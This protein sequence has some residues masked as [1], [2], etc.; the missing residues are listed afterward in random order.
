MFL[1][2]VVLYEIYSKKLVTKYFLHVSVATDMIFIKSHL[3]IFSPLIICSF[4]YIFHI[5]PHYLKTLFQSRL[6]F[7][8]DDLFTNK[9]RIKCSFTLNSCSILRIHLPTEARM[10]V[11]FCD[12]F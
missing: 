11:V 9:G 8:F 5:K 10:N 1:N 12:Y 2:S 7:N 3:F 6:L 4:Y